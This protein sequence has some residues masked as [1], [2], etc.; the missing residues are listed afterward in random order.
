M[1]DVDWFKPYNDT[2][3]HQAG[4]TRLRTVAGLI[5]S[6]ARR[7][8]DLAARYGGE[9]FPFIAAGTAGTELARL[10][11]QVRNNLEALAIPHAGSTFGCV[12][13]SVGIAAVVPANEASPTG[14]LL[15]ADKA[16][17]DAKA[18]GRNRLVV[19]ADIEPARRFVRF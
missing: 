7:G 12:T 18:G 13:V 4:D 14:L 11:E 2:Y 19:A 9:E 10:A 15:A 16:L 1:F 5:G 6:Q 8:S 3:G 17:Y